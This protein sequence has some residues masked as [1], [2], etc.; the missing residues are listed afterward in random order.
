VYLVRCWQDGQSSFRISDDVAR[1]QSQQ[2]SGL[3]I[4]CHPVA[5]FL[6]HSS[7]RYIPFRFYYVA[8]VCHTTRLEL[9]LQFHEQ[10]HVRRAL[11]DLAGAV[12]DKGSWDG[13]RTRS[14]RKSYL[15]DHSADYRPLHELAD[16]CAYL[17]F[18]LSVYRVGFY[19]IAVAVRAAW[20]GVIVDAAQCCGTFNTVNT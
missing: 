20:E 16:I 2:V 11:R 6:H 12:P 13:E 7:D 15:W 17:C 9:W 10:H 3:P 14:S 18:C 4:V 1:S 8:L 19:C 5:D